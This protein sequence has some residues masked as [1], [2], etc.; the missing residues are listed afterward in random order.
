MANRVKEKLRKGL[1]SVGYWVSLPSPSV[2]EIMAGFGMDWLMIDAEHGPAGYERIEDLLR[3]IEGSGVVPLMRVAENNMALIKKALDRGAYG[4]LVP[5]VNNA[6]EAAAAVSAA[7]YPPEGRR[8]VAGT[9]VS[10]FGMSLKEYY[11]TWN[12]D[13]LVAIQVETRQGLD[14][15]EA[16][17]A[18]PGV[19]VLFIGPVDLSANL[20][21]FQQFD[22]PEFLGAVSRILRAAKDNG[23]AAGYMAFD[24]EGVLNKVDEGFQ[25]IAGGTDAR[26][27]MDVLRGAMQQIDRGLK[28]RSGSEAREG[29][30]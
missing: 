27:L 28:E 7:K 21:L 25:F 2:A 15:V 6:A 10:R 1:P 17:A 30:I 16:I 11:H 14:N 26:L 8:G 24:P 12:D 19:D 22:H 23:I 29:G 4:V 5:L 13:V 20:G 3:A 18:V 9:R